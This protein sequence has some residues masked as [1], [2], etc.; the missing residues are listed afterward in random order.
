[1]LKTRIISAVIGIPVLLWIAW[2]GGYFWLA[3]TLLA[4]G[5]ALFEFYRAFQASGSHPLWLI[6]CLLASVVFFSDRLNGRL[7]LAILGILALSVMMVV[8]FY[9]RYHIID[10]AVTW[11]GA[12]YIGL[13]FGYAARLG[14]LPEHARIILMAFLLTWSSDSGAYAAGRLW[15]RH[16]L[17]S[18]LSPN[19][20][21]EGLIGGYILT[22]AVALAGRFILPGYSTLWYLGTGMICGLLAPLGDLF[23]SAIKR[24]LEI[25]DYGRLIPGHGG[26]LDRFDSFM[27][28]VPALYYLIGLGG[29]YFGA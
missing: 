11:L 4:T 23:A 1:V 2:L 21:W 28:V 8:C 18:L 7:D 16:K 25:K 13:L 5:V 12:V 26:V 22:I 9:P 3:F 15:G 29:S 6:G 27:L 17:A 19:K 10:L 14:F 20:T 24:G